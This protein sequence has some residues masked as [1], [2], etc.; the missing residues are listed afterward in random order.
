MSKIE[1]FYSDLAQ[2]RSL[3]LRKINEQE[4][5]ADP[6]QRLENSIKKKNL[7]LGNAPRPDP[8]LRISATEH[9]KE[10]WKNQTGYFHMLTRIKVPIR[11]IRSR[12]PVLFRGNY[13]PVQIFAGDRHGVNK[14]EK[15]ERNWKLGFGEEGLRCKQVC[16]VTKPKIKKKRDR[17]AVPKASKQLMFMSFILILK[18]FWYFYFLTPPKR[19]V[20]FFFFLKQEFIPPPLFFYE[21]IW[22]KLIHL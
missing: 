6:N 22:W 9:R 17:T 13:L 19:F 8:K 4:E 3:K 20:M 15:V 18:L 16:G 12:C 11:W 10:D 14:K 21:R 2:V 5:K 7:R 1:Y